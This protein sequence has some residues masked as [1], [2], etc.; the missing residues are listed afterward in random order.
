MSWS[1]RTM[2]CLPNPSRMQAARWGGP[3]MSWSLRT[4]TCLSNPSGV[5]AARWEF[6]L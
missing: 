2:T 1:L 3:D 4:M 5:Q 6:M